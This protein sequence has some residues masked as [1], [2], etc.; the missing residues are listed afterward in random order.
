MVLSKTKNLK[1]KNVILFHVHKLPSSFIAASLVKK[2][3]FNFIEISGNRKIM[4]DVFEHLS[5]FFF[6]IQ[7]RIYLY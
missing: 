6:N 1:I 3:T 5:V 7:K 2:K 4:V